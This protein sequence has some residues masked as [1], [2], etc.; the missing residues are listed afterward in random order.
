M[1]EVETL[2]EDKKE[3]YHKRTRDYMITHAE[4]LVNAISGNGNKALE[5]KK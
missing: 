1:D 2:I 3:E 4:V 5:S